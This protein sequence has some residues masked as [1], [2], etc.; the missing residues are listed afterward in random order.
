MSDIRIGLSVKELTEI[1][2]AAVQ[3]QS[4]EVQAEVKQRAKHDGSDP[5]S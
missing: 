2:N 1:Y 3:S 4:P 5:I